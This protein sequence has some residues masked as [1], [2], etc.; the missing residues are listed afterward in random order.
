MRRRA[1]VP[2]CSNM[3]NAVAL[4]VGMPPAHI[5][6]AT[7]NESALTD[8]FAAVHT[9]LAPTSARLSVR[10]YGMHCGACAD[11]IERAV[12]AVPGVI[13]AQASAAGQSATVI[14]NPSIVSAGLWQVAIRR[15]GYRAEPEGTA[16]AWQLR[17]ALEKQALWR[18]FVAGFCAMQVMMMA[19][20]AYFAAPGDLAPDLARLLN[21]ASWLLSLPVLMFSAAP[22][23]Q[24][25]WRD[26]RF[27]RVGMDVPVALALAVSFLVSTGA[28][29]VP[30]GIFGD[31]V[32]FDS[33]TMFVSFLLLARWVQLRLAHRAANRLEAAVG[34]LPRTAQRLTPT[35]CFE[36][37]DASLLRAGDR[38]QVPRGEAFVADGVI[39]QGQT[40]VDEALLSGESTPMSRREGDAVVAGSLNLEAPVLVQVHKTGDD[41]RYAAIVAL[42]RSALSQRPGFASWADQWAGP[43]LWTVLALSAIAYL[44]WSVVDPPRALGVA[45]AVLVVTCPCAL[46]L[47]TPATL[48][49]A[50]GHLASK[51][52]LVQRL[53][54]LEVLNRVDAVSMDKTGT[55][56]DIA[57]FGLS[58]RGTGL[59]DTETSIDE[60]LRIANSLAQRSSHPLSHAVVKLV[61]SLSLE[62][63]PLPRS[64][65]TPNPGR[66]NIDWFELEEFAG[67][68][69]QARDAQGARWR[70]GA[71]HWAA[72]G[73]SEGS[74]GASN[75]RVV[76][77][78]EGHVALAFD[79]AET[80]RPGAE[81]AVA[82]MHDR[83]QSVHLLSGDGPS[84]VR[85]AARRLGVDSNTSA[86]SPG[87]K[88][89]QLKRAQ[90]SG[91]CVA[92]VGDGVNDAPV[93]AGADVS[94]AMGQGALVA[95][96]CA[97]FIV[98]AGRPM[99]IVL[100]MATAS[101]ASRIVRQNLLWAAAYNAL[102]VPL[103]LLGYL[104]PWAAGAGM[105]L[106][107]LGVVLNALRAAH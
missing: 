54:A 29:L 90:A 20:P 11:I 50:A 60:A 66:Q 31:E 106:S 51:G 107:S 37:V 41:T 56:S 104:P 93:L 27:C 42:M 96:Y 98:L 71:P 63:R 13:K 91:Q 16:S 21:W 82:A 75:A 61:A 33:T 94:F 64:P 100:T 86:A 48:V 1:N 97:D 40:R 19:S 8:A 68:G 65:L 47:A 84:R 85:D 23:F 103:A 102:C 92:M 44:G 45:L 30:G 5:D 25:A 69:L 12:L 67:L 43:F 22:F 88:L 3:P 26:L 89:E 46:S 32:Y 81:Q 62:S 10:L 36:T 70:L 83:G 78:R 15:A 53:A 79:A 6:I 59:A 57:A 74:D 49:A 14:W 105:A 4:P 38:V 2:E 7:G 73:A 80:L 9:A 35:E 39:L 77:T 17:R 24:S 58:V 95:R 72:H 28:T 55:L 18:L 87:S 76:L 99:D 34:D 101:K 52:V